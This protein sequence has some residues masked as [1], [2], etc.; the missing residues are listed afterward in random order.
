MW[1]VVG[2]ME[3]Q[4]SADLEFAAAGRY[5]RRRL[6][7]EDGPSVPVPLAGVGATR[8][9]RPRERVELGRV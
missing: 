9:G 3:R 5:G 8:H 1:L 7:G 4:S 2:R 6:A